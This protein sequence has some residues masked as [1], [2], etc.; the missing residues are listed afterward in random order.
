MN[1]HFVTFTAVVLLALSAS[2]D[3]GPKNVKILKG[4]TALQL[5]R[6]MNLMRAG[7][8]VGCDYC[9]VISEE[10]GWQFALDDKHE[11]EEAR[12]M[13][14]LTIGIN[15]K[16]FDGKPVVTCFTCHNGNRRPALTASLPQAQPPFPTPVTDRSKF[17][18]AKD[19]IAKYIT[20]IGGPEAA[21]KIETAPTRVLKGT[22]LFADGKTTSALEVYESGDRILVNTTTDEG[23][24]ITQFTDG[25][26]GWVRDKDGVHPMRESQLENFRSI[27]A[28]FRP[29]DHSTVS[30]NARVATKARIDDRDMW[31]VSSRN[32]KGDTRL[33]F[34][35]ETGL[36]RR[37]LVLVNGP[38]GKLPEQTDFDDYRSV[39]GAKV[40]F[41]ITT[42][43]VD[44][45]IGS[46]R[47][48]TEITI[49][50]PVDEGM[51]KGT[52]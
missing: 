34:D 16:Y 48:A 45:W 18:A 39:N 3:E 14:L 47:R 23:N 2:G 44:P 21:Q 38:I 5:Q 12:E 36:L 42:S 24:P 26:G 33:Y 49:G 10:K 27:A 35:A 50:G 40:P 52:E 46:T 29:F 32:E 30:E 31:V 51:F 9:H 6:Q 19:I 17:P 15:E 25:V 7:L 1:R 22:R 20:A 43:F 8:G 11:K 4:L 37:R 28:A 13:I 41:S